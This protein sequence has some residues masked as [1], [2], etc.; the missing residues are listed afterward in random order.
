MAA[1]FMVA[2]MGMHLLRGEMPLEPIVFAQTFGI[3]FLPSIPCIAAIALMFECVPFLSGRGGDLLYFFFWTL[4]L[5]LPAVLISS[6]EGHEWILA[7]DIT[8]M[9][10]LVKEI[11]AVTG[12]T[13]F[14]IGYAPFNAT[15]S[16]FFF[17]GLRWIPE[18][19]ILRVASVL[20]T[21][22]FFGIALAV[23]RRFDP[24]RRISR[25]KTDTGKIARLRQKLVSV[26]LRIAVLRMGWIVGPPSLVRASILDVRLT[27]ALYPMFFIAIA[28][29]FLFGLFAPMSAIRDTVLSHHL[30]D[31]RA[32]PCLH[33]H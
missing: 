11:I 15:L 9:G 16:P 13:N 31:P 6:S 4:T 17:P 12:A 19:L 20:F 1:V 27:L 10:F 22:P 32:S 2:C 23:F 3:I 29:S 28:A 21:I 24:A 25:E 18:L 5:T 7:A 8:G 14:T 26:W 33:L 30:F